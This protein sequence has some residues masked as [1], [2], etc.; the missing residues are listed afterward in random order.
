M[1]RFLFTKIPAN[2][3]GMATRMV[4]IAGALADRGHGV[5]IL[6][7]APAPQKFIAE[8]GLTSLPCQQR[9]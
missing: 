9:S 5:A 3:L 2:D 4:P 1:A 7:P 8:A 6:N